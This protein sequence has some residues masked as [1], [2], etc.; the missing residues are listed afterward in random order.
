MKIDSY[1]SPCTKL[2]PKWIKDVNKKPDTLNL[3]EGKLGKSLELIDTS[4]KFLN[5]TSV[6]HAL[7]SRI[8]K[9]DLLKLESFC[10]AKDIV[11]K[12]N[13]QPTHWKKQTN[14]QTNKLH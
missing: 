8:D 9:W 12:T 13:Q 6:A 7:R 3:I 10:K 14:K 4:R 2:K 5:T 1:W 11:N